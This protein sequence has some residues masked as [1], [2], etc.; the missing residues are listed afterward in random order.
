MTAATLHLVRH[1]E[2]DN[3]GGVVYGRLPGYGITERG[4]AM[5]DAAATA[6]AALPVNRLVASPLLRT[7]LS[8]RPIAAL[9]GLEIEPDVRVVEA[10]NRF[11]GTRLRGRAIVRNPKVWPYFRNPVRPSWG[12]PYVRIVAR[13][14]AA[15]A[16]AFADTAEGD[17]VV[18]SHQL[19]IWMVHRSVLHE[20]LPHDPRRRRCALSS[21]TSFQQVDGRLV[22]TGYQEPA[23]ALLAGAVDQGA[24]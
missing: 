23:A 11:E 9:F 18:V 22:E 1:A 3:P 10:G 16:D 14:R 15:I 5:A 4:E 24:T 2:V 6:L 8:A 19:P 17:V 13:M 21:I 12:E 7:Q 20:P